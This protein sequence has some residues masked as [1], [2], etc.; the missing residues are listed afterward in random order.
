MSRL[1]RTFNPIGA[2]LLKPSARF[3]SLRMYSNC[4]GPF[5]AVH[6]DITMPYI[7]NYGSKEQIERFIPEMTAGRCIG[8]IAMTE[9]GAGRSGSERAEASPRGSRTFR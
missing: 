5:F 4:T 9:P 7:S 3:F 6:S 2:A 1:F 8:A